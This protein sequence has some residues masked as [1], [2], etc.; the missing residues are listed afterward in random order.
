MKTE[1]R[2]H[3]RVRHRRRRHRR[4]P[5]RRARRGRRPED[6]QRDPRRRGAR[7]QRPRRLRRRRRRQRLAP[8]LRAPRPGRALGQRAQPGARR[9]ARDA[10]S[11]RRPTTA[12]RTSSPT[13]T[14]PAW[15]TRATRP[16]GTRSSSAATPPAREFIAF[17]LSRPAGGGRHE[18]QRLGRQRARPG[19]DP[20]PPGRR[21]VARSP[22]PTPRST[23]S[24]TSKASR[25]HLTPNPNLKALHD[26]G[27]SIWLDTLSRELL[28]SG[29]FSE[30]VR[31]YSVTG[32]TSNPTIFAKAITGSDRYDEQLRA[33]VAAGTTDP[34][35]SVLRDRARG[36]PPRRGGAAPDLR[37]DRRPRRL[38]LLRVHPRPG[39]RHARHGRPGARAVAAPRRART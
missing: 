1:R 13:S 25:C 28:E 19:A 8:V 4:R 3:D 5:A 10:R 38:R 2:A 30:L 29:E 34:K 14:T 7:D 21:H 6:R 33:A 17:W 22:T 16:N 11:G 12:S 39:R 24:S 15:S 26:A 9:G 27:V 20:L 32:A 23:H 31:D 36:C 35:D 18:P 37:R